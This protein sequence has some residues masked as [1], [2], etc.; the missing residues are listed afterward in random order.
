MKRAAMWLLPTLT[1]TSIGSLTFAT[2]QPRIDEGS[3]G[4]E[5]KHSTK[6]VHFAHDSE[7]D[8]YLTSIRSFMLTPPR[9][10]RFG[11][12]RIPTFHGRPKGDI[13]G[14]EAVRELAKEYQFGS[15]VVGAAPPDMID[16]YKQYNLKNPN[17]PLT[18]PKYRVTP[19]HMMWDSLRRQASQTKDTQSR[20][21][22]VIESTKAKVEKEGY[23]VYAREVKLNGET[24]W[25][26][27]KSVVAT[28]KSCYSCHANIKEGAPIG[29]VMAVLAKRQP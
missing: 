18:I 14:F 17:Q 10:G 3:K 2:S 15:Y 19:V 6:V 29:H 22:E 27:V 13:P 16:S 8:T 4:S 7:I 9:D 25:I 21:T 23:D 5:S 20:L 26:M 28:D 24:A 12:S 11:A 1:L